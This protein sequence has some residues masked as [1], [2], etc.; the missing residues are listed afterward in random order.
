M[1]KQSRIQRFLRD[2]S[3]GMI[4]LSAF[5]LPAILGFAGLGLDVSGWYMERRHVQNITDMAAIDVANSAINFSDSDLEAQLAAFMAARDE[6]DSGSDTVTMN[7]PPTSGDYAG[8]NNFYEVTVSRQVTLKFLSAFYAITGDNLTVNVS[9]RAVSGALVVGT[10]CVVALDDS[11]DRALEFSGNTT[12]GTDCGVTANSVSDE[13]LYIGGSATLDTTSVQA[14][15]DISVQGG[16]TLTTTSPPQSLSQSADDP[17]TNLPIPTDMGCDISGNQRLR[18]GDSLDAAGGV[19]RVCGDITIQGTGVVFEPGTYVIE[20]GDFN[21]L[22]GADFTGSGVTFIFT[23]DTST[24]IGSIKINGGASAV[25]SAPADDGNVYEGI[26]FYQ[27]PNAE[28]RGRDSAASFTGGSSMTMDGIIY[29]PSSDVTF[30]GG[31]SSA[32]S[33]LQIWSAT[34]KFTGDS[35]IDNDETVCSTMNI[36]STS[37]KRILLVE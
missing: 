17:F 7:N 23:G 34:V 10:Q 27:D 4:T 18:D 12:I 20:G 36:E 19:L 11:A 13:A 21:A 2:E 22:A 16:G 31:T 30:S 37:Q 26:L 14:V 5:M 33:C 15:G 8:N 32:P 28:Y 25:L 9:G 29:M 24:D 35:S 1:K 3:A 6:Y